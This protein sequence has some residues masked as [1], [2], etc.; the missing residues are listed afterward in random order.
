VSPSGHDDLTADRTGALMARVLDEI[1]EP[2][3]EWLEAQH[4]FFVASA[5]RADEGHVN[6][7]PK[8]GDT[9]RVLERGRVAY[10]DLTGSGVETVAHVR[11]NRRLTIMFCAFDGRPNIV[12]LF[13]RAEVHEVGT[14]S[15]ASLAGS[16]PA[17]PGARSIISLDVDRIQTSCG[18]SVPLMS[19][20]GD[21]HD[22]ERWAEKKGPEGLAD[23]W[24]EKN[25]T[26]ID[27]L[28]G[29][30]EAGR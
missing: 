21:R 19:F 8:G 20:D 10:L 5:P 7:S 16:F 24:A 30:T 3:R 27:G 11:E 22:L 25:L 6:V 28:D 2:M 23:Y 12:R 29:L 26:S 15:F 18:L 4:V 1:T 14:D 13:G 9:F 17:V